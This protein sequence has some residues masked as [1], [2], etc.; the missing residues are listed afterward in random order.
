MDKD[1]IKKKVKAYLNSNHLVDPRFHW[2]HKKY[3]QAYE[4]YIIA[5]DEYWKIRDDYRSFEKNSKEEK[6]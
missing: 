2:I 6:E 4:N 5:R 3:K 1:L